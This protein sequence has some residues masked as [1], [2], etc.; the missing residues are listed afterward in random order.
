MLPI[1]KSLRC[2]TIEGP[3]FRTVIYRL[4]KA[5]VFLSGVLILS[6]QIK[7]TFNTFIQNRTSFAMMQGTVQSLV[8]P[9]IV[10]CP[11]KTKDG[12]P[13][14]FLVNV[15]N[16]NQFDEDFFWIRNKLNFSLSRYPSHGQLM[17][18]IHLNLGKNRDE[19]GNL[20]VTVEELMNPML[21]LCYAFI[22]DI[23]NFKLAIEDFAVFLLNIDTNLKEVS[24]FFTSE[25]ARY[26][27]LVYDLGRLMPFKISLNSG[28]TVGVN[29]KKRV[30]KKLPSSGNCKQYPKNQSFMKCMLEKQVECYRL[31][32]QTCQC[33][34]ENNHKTQ[35]QLFPIPSWKACTNDTEYICG[36]DQMLSCYYNKMVTKACPLSCE[37]EKYKG[38]KIYLNQYPTDSKK[39]IMKIKYSTMTVQMYKEYEVQDIYSFIGT[40]GGSLGLFIGFSYTGFFGDLSNF[41]VKIKN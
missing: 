3:A 14:N 38:Q 33:I 41:F 27:L 26:G 25:E 6:W 18:R 20:L 23:E 24:V 29:L 11:R 4:A 28:T 30:W 31:G 22:P 16:K 12:F 19:E 9:T 5:L 21:G 2:P 1:M 13:S 32:N 10:F 39:M 34:P 15:S 37:V 40:V 36:F 8:P 17:S 35:F 7:G